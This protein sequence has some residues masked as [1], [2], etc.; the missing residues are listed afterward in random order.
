MLLRNSLILLSFDLKLSWMYESRIWFR[1]GASVCT[2]YK[3]RMVFT[4]LN[5]KRKKN[6]Q[7]K[8]NVAYKA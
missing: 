1:A 2:T 5:Y 7:Q 3:L 8:L 4:F 6:M